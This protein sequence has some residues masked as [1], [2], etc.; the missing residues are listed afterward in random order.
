MKRTIRR[1]GIVATIAAALV[2]MTNVAAFAVDPSIDVNP[3]KGISHTDLGLNNL[4]VIIGA[5]LVIFMQAGFALVET[6]FCRAKHASHVV[7]TNFA[8]FGLGFVA[9]FLVGFP[10]MFS[11]FSYAPFGMTSPL[12]TSS[13]IHFGD[14]G[15]WVFLWGKSGWGLSGLGYS[16]PVAAFFLYMVAFMDTTATIPTGAMAERWKWKAFVGWGL[17]CG[18]L[19]YPI[20]GGWTWGGGWLSKLGN[21]V[22]LGFGYVDFAGSG[23]V[24]AMGGIAGL[25]GAIVLGARIGKFGPDGKPRTLAAH[26][27]PMAML[28][29]FILLFGW[30]GF[31]AASTF[32]ATDLRFTVVAVNTAIAAAFGAT[33]AMFYCQKR[34]GKPDP[35]M[36]VNGMLAGLVAITAPCAFV[37]PWAA[38]VIGVDRRGDHRRVGVLLRAQGDRRP[39]R[40]HLGARRGRHLRC[41]LCRH[42]LRRPVRRRLERH[43]PDST[44]SGK[45][46]TG[47]L[48]GTDGK[49]F[50]SGAFGKLG[51]GQ[52]GAQAIGCLV[53]IFVMGGL[54]F[55]FFKLQDKLMKGGIRSEEADEIG[56][57]DLPEMGALAYDNLQVRELDVVG[58]DQEI[59][60]S[61]GPSQEPT[62]GR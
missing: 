53:I 35:G 46:V 52:L 14:S 23:V 43:R 9:F 44:T 39:G 55:L 18:A 24:H 13:L 19:Y 41:A 8:I 29:T 61:G 20:F 17:F 26:N 15:N 56:G 4:W 60:M 31:N 21:S 33:V 32:A 2:L 58:V 45:G 3:I 47:I 59:V 51:F 10:I 40:R 12:S 49:L 25:A 62:T 1:I 30:F 36:M 37:Q 6:G 54:A 38:A 48:Y 34:M 7:S 42:L 57:L 22:D 50:G 5:V 16:V 11:G 27:I 28:G